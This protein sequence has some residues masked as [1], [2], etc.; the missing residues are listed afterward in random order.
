M[1]IDLREMRAY[2][3]QPV[4]SE[5]QEVLEDLMW[6]DEPLPLVG[7]V[8]V[9]ASAFYDQQRV[10][11]TLTVSGKS[12]RRC[13]R[14]VL[15]FEE[16][17]ERQDLLEIELDDP[18]ASYVELRPWIAAA[19]RLAVSPRPLCRTDC[20][21]LCAGCGADLNVEEHREGCVELAPARDPRL[22]KLRE[23]L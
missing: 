16:E 14:C 8:R 11:L 4:R 13:S 6:C 7:A 2:P 19:V 18:N 20:Q 5:G 21:G 12:V 22:E 9:V 23:L 3:G 17:F 1:R 10:F 15:E